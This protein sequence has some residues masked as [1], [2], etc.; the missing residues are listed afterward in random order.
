MINEF[1]GFDNNGHPI[2]IKYACVVVGPEDTCVELVGCED[3][4]TSEKYCRWRQARFHF[5]SQEV[6]K[7]SDNY[8]F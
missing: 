2:I 8:F 6:K 3:L 1:D 4:P 7:L 5:D